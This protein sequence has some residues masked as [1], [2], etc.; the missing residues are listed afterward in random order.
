MNKL[1]VSDTGDSDDLSDLNLTQVR[2]IG[3]LDGPP[4]SQPGPTRIA[5]V[6]DATT[7]SGEF[8]P[9]RKISVEAAR[10]LLRPMFAATSELQVSILY[11]RGDGEFGSLGWFSNPEE[12]AQ[13]IAGIQ[14]KPGWTQ[15][16]TAFQHILAEAKKQPIQTALIITDAVEKRGPRNPDGDDLADLA[17]DAIRLKRAGCK[18]TFVYKGSIAGGC[19]LDRAGPHAEERIRELKQDNEGTVLLYDPSDPQ[20]VK[21]LA[22]VATEAALRAKGDVRGARAL[23][24]HFQTIPLDLTAVGEAVLVGKC[25]T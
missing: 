18:L 25:K 9:S 10:K 13:T 3:A 19:P 11:F 21:G 14:H 23:L 7:S 8:L 15:H 4:V 6:V 2:M 1:T 12:A 16:G 24:P 20:F 5:V 22:E 17:K